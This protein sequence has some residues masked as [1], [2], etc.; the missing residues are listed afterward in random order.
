MPAVTV[1]IPFYNRVEWLLQSVESV[2]A[3]TFSNFE[4]LLVDDGSDTSSDFL[5]TFKDPRIRYVKQENKGPAAAR[6]L[7]ISLAQGKYIAFLDSDDLFLPDKIEKQFRIMEEHQSVGLSHSSYLRIDARGE[8]I[9]EVQSGKSSGWLY[10]EIICGCAIATPTVMIRTKIL[11]ELNFDESIKLGEDILLWVQIARVSEILGID[12]PLTQVRIHGDNA[13]L[14]PDK[15]LKFTK[16]LIGRSFGEDKKL[17]F[18]LQFRA[19]SAMYM[20]QVH[21]YYR[22]SRFDR[23][24]LFLL[25]SLLFQPAGVSEYINIA[26]RRF[27]SPAAKRSIND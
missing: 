20:H 17:T 5:Q 26:I 18:R 7:G 1:I 27:F 13:I 25:L 12:E 3:Q 24:A 19:Y 23:C 15:Q 16:Y 10:P 2:L 21:L 11:S 14:D 8:K 22:V 6:N 9:D 4:L